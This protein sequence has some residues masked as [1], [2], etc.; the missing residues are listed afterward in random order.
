L[1]SA[2]PLFVALLTHTN[3]GNAGNRTDVFAVPA[4][5]ALGDASTLR[6]RRTAAPAPAASASP[7]LRV[8]VSANIARTM[9]R[10]LPGWRSR[11][12]PPVEP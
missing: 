11:S 4:V 8:L 7:A 6:A 5:S 9:E 2:G 3:A 10:R 12:V 1:A